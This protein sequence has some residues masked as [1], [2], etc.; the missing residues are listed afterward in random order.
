MEASTFSYLAKK[1]ESEYE[2][3]G[4]SDDLSRHFEA[5]EL[6]EMV[7]GLQKMISVEQEVQELR[8]SVQ[9]QFL[10]LNGRK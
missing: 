7:S 10:F 2:S 8:E 4:W 6:P 9:K 5:A 1:L 3:C